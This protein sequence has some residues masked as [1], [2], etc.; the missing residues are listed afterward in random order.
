MAPSVQAQSAVVTNGFVLE[1]GGK[2]SLY[3]KEEWRL[4]QLP[5]PAGLP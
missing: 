5:L 1:V 4:L 3:L 2:A